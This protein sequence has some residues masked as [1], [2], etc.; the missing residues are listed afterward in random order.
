MSPCRVCGG[1]ASGTFNV[2]LAGEI[3][4]CSTHLGD[5]QRVGLRVL[6][7][8]ADMGVLQSTIAGAG[9]VLDG[10][11]RIIKGARALAQPP[12]KPA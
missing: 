1:D 9:S 4:L 12:D 2:P 11:D 5:A 3:P 6:G 7:A 8:V 10:L